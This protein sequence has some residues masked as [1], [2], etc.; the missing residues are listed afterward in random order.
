MF[1]VGITKH[2]VMHHNSRSIMKIP[3][4]YIFASISFAS[5]VYGEAS[6]KSCDSNVTGE[7]IISGTCVFGQHVAGWEVAGIV[8]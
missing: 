5:G 6:G 7:A 8:K 2:A 3:Y 1:N 4:L